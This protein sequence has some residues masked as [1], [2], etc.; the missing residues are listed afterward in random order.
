MFGNYYMFVV[1]ENDEVLHL[2]RNPTWRSVVLFMF[3]WAIVH[4]LSVQ[5]QYQY[6]GYIC[7]A[8]GLWFCY[9]ATEKYEECIFDKKK[10]TVTMM[11]ARFLQKFTI[12]YNKKIVSELSEIIAVTVQSVKPSFL[13]V[14]HQVTLL[15]INGLTLSITAAATYGNKK[16]HRTVANKINTF[17]N[18][19]PSPFDEE[20]DDN[21]EDVNDSDEDNEEKKTN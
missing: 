1:K 18:L 3:L 12:G 19:S 7:Y 17:L 21:D 9:L 4:F 13:G 8:L 2:K 6:L 15:Y 11:N 10:S 5:A 14:A 16:L 20:G